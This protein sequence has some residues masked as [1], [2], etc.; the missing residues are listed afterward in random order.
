MKNRAEESDWFTFEDVPESTPAK[1]PVNKPAN[2]MQVVTLAVSPSQSV[3]LDE[4]MLLEWEKALEAKS[5]G[6]YTNTPVPA[7]LLQGLE[8][9]THAPSEGP[10]RSQMILPLYDHMKTAG[11][12]DAVNE[13]NMT[14]MEVV[15]V[16]RTFME[17]MKDG[18]GQ[19]RKG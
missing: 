8:W 17:E 18:N 15:A 14:P 2:N 1:T 5:K 19:I 13:N 7:W 11:Y 3:T 10:V 12:L 9:L 4:H 16:L 6:R